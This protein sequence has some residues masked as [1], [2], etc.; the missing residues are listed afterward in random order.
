MLMVLISSTNMKANSRLSSTSSAVTRI[1][2]W[3]TSSISL[4]AEM[5]SITTGTLR[6]N[7]IVKYAMFSKAS[8]MRKKTL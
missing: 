8:R 4:T 7:A 5:T 6:P 1:P 2:S 3:V